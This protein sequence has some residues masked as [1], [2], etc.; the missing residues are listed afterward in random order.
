MKNKRA[1]SFSSLLVQPL[2][3]CVYTVDKKKRNICNSTRYDK[4]N[5]NEQKGLNLF[6][7]VK[8]CSEKRR[9]DCLRLKS[10]SG[11]SSRRSH[12]RVLLVCKKNGRCRLRVLPVAAGTLLLRLQRVSGSCS[13]WQR[14]ASCRTRSSPAAA[15]APLLLSQRAL[16][17]AQPL[18]LS[19]ASL[20][21]HRWRVL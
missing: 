3:L 14:P 6:W 18:A 12:R 16:P 19:S 20:E 2:P 5:S 9:S 10:S 7:R 17:R 15:P 11:S 8:Y 13:R 21:A 4:T 1:T